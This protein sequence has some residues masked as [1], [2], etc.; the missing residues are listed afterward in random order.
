MGNIN[1]V[2]WVF[3]R[4]VYEREFTLQELS[5]RTGITRSYLSLFANGKYRLNEDQLG[6]LALVLG[7]SI[8]EIEGPAH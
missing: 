5:D 6:K 1:N 2:N 3:K 8:P 4:I 7:V